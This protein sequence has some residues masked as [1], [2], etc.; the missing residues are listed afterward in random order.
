MPENT[1]SRN[2]NASIHDNFIRSILS[3]KK[4]AVD[5]FKSC[6]PGFIS[7]QLDFT[8]L[9]QLPG[10]YLSEELKKTM[11]DI[12]YSCRRKGG[13]S[14]V[15]VSLL[16]EHKS[17]PDKY[18]PIQMGSY[19]FS[20]F[21]KQATAK[22][23]LS[24]VIPVLLY[25][26]KGKW[27]YRRLSGLFDGIDK[28]WKQYLPDFEYVYNNLGTLTDTEVQK[29]NNKFLKASFLAL[30]HSF[31]KE[32]LGRNAVDLLILASAG[33]KA[34]QKGFIIYLYSRGDLKEE[35]VLNSLPEP[36]KKTIMSTLDIYIEKGR[37]KGIEEGI[38]KGIEKG[39]KKGIEKKSL[40]FIQNLLSAG[41]FSVSEIAGFAG[42]TES[43]VKKVRTS[44][45]KKK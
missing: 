40:E 29:L 15:K 41:K 28:E 10:T 43:F 8:S 45:K 12:V 31:E 37:K 42:V 22:E 3:N 7:S 19:I 44:L 11:S 30:K 24:L 6:L 34:L 9:Q 38:E 23:P 5:Y 14:A 17:Y 4:M 2:N 26:G 27:Q 33:P 16:V 39:I 25:H 32:W 1:T 13:K 36:I 35:N 21:Q 18:T 20:A